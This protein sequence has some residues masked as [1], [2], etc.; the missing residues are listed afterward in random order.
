MGEEVKV[1]SLVR[2]GLSEEYVFD[3]YYI[4]L[5]KK[6]CFFFCVVC[7]CFVYFLGLLFSFIL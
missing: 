4:E 7:I 5:R 1:G 3:I 6:L 2:I